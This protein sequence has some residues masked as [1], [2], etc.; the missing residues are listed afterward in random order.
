MAFSGVYEAVKVGLALPVWY[1]ALKIYWL[2]DVDMLHTL[3]ASDFIFD[4][5]FSVPQ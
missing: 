5:N 1:V 2:F 4:F 3:V